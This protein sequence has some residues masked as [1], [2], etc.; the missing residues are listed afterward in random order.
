[1]LYHVRS[2]LLQSNKQELVFTILDKVPLEELRTFFK[3][4]LNDLIAEKG[5][6][7]DLVISEYIQVL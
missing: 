4:F 5:L 3:G 6:N 1:M 7:S 2:N